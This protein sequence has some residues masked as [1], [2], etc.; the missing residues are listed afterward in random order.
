MLCKG[1]APGHC[2]DVWQS[3]V[4]I[5][6]QGFP[7]TVIVQA[8]YSEHERNATHQLPPLQNWGGGGGASLPSSP[9]QPT[10]IYR[11]WHQMTSPPPSTHT[12]RHKYA[13]MLRE[14]I[15]WSNFW[16]PTQRFMAHWKQQGQRK[17]GR[18]MLSLRAR[19]GVLFINI[20][21]SILVCNKTALS[22][23]DS[24]SPPFCSINVSS[25]SSSTRLAGK[26]ESLWCNM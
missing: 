19:G 10:R 1:I 14:K 8:R 26:L 20:W 21:E 12:H 22:I 23:S 7:K 18:D 4:L 15:G 9:P 25:R 11:E 17:R 2:W 3:S 24:Y 6:V 5:V 16:T 13:P